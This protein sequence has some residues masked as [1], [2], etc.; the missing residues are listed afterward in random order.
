MLITSFDMKG[1]VHSGFIPRGQTV[2]RAYY[3]EVLKRLPEALHRKR[4]ELWPK[5]LDSQPL[6]CSS[7]Q[8]THFRVISGPDIYY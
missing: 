4:P 5:R 1:V 7:P 3:A 8:D 2:N 6:R